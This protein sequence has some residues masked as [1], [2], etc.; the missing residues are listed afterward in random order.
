MF[1]SNKL[2]W[3]NTIQYYSW[4]YKTSTEAV[5]RRCFVRK[6]VLKNLVN[7]NWTENFLNL[8]SN[9][10]A[11][12][13]NNTTYRLKQI[14][15]YN[16]CERYYR[17]KSRFCHQFLYLSQFKPLSQLS[18]RLFGVLLEFL[19]AYFGPYQ[20]FLADNYFRKEVHHRRLKEFWIHFSLLL[21]TFKH[22]HQVEYESETV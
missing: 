7:F 16:L 9:K 11:S 3:Y 5:S 8:F 6:G 15:K 14:H 2:Q 22:W 19:K 10:A 13:S 17:R 4:E 1:F 12:G 18:S 20:I 21:N